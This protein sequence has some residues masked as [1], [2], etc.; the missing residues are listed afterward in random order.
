MC[1]TGLSILYFIYTCLYYACFIEE[2][3][4]LAAAIRAGAEEVAGITRD[5]YMKRLTWLR[6]ATRFS[7]FFNNDERRKPAFVRISNVLE[8]LKLDS[9]DGRIRKQPYCVVLS[10][11]PGCGKTGTAM[12]IAAKFMR[13]RHGKFK[14]TDIVTLNETDE[15]QS[16][17]RTNHRVVIF[18]DVGAEASELQ[19]VNPWR[20][21]IDFVNNI[22][23]TALNPNL[24]LKG[25]VYIEPELVIITT[26]L[27]HD[28]KLRS[29]LACPEAIYRRIN[30]LLEL[31][32][33][34]Q[35]R[36]VPRKHPNEWLKHRDVYSTGMSFESSNDGWNHAYI[37]GSKIDLPSHLDIVSIMEDL[38]ID[39]EKHLD[40]QEDYVLKMNSLLDDEEQQQSAFSC[41]WHDQVVPLLPKKIPLS[42][43][44]EKL[45][46]WYE[47]CRRKFCVTWDGPICQT[48]W[49]DEYSLSSSDYETFEPQAGEIDFKDYF[50]ESL[51]LSRER[52]LD[53]LFDAENYLALR[54]YMNDNGNYGPT[55]FGFVAMHN[56][57]LINP[58]RVAC[59]SEH[60]PDTDWYSPSELDE[61]YVRWFDRTQKIEETTLSSQERE[62]DSC[63]KIK[64]PVYYGEIMKFLQHKYKNIEFDERHLC[65]PKM[66]EM[67]RNCQ[68]KLAEMNAQNELPN[69]P[70]SLLVYQLLRRAYH[71]GQSGFEVETNINGL[72]VDASFRSGD[73]L[74]ICEAKTHGEPDDQIKRY[75]RDVAVDEPVIGIGINY[76]RYVIYYAGDVPEED[77]VR[78]AKICSAVFIF[79]QKFGKYF[80]V[81]FPFTKYKV[82]DDTYPPPKKW[83]A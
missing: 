62:K 50:P 6:E 1:W 10:G 78:A 56:K 75:I 40:E 71:A 26:N 72:T 65:C 29:W 42:P 74:V 37:P 66:K 51:P 57:P 28:L 35:A 48:S 25:N 11:P 73:T 81:S 18:D 21:I 39:F 47:R 59:Y 2:T 67:L 27:C 43:E 61:A 45:L 41:F 24:E 52:L 76:S 54:Q 36:I 82:H 34:Y 38:A 8:N 16:E 13:K 5:R 80:G 68:R 46:P 83:V 9:A 64:S 20:K 53:F 12:K 55:K 33:Y 58:L 49:S 23:K 15:F 32:D 60:E 70:S 69:H 77:L 4:S 17:Y 19:G 3:L 22:R 31:R 7:I 14:P 30:V 63:A 44:M 79:F